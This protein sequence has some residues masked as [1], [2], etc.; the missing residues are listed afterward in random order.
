MSQDL[1]TAIAAARLRIIEAPKLLAQIRLGSLQPA[2]GGRPYRYHFV[3]ENMRLWGKSLGEISD[4]AH[5]I[6]AI[7]D[8]ALTEAAF[9]QQKAQLGPKEWAKKYGPWSKGCSWEEIEQGW[10]EHAGLLQ[11]GNLT[12]LPDGVCALLVS[13]QHRT[14]VCLRLLAIEFG[15]SC[16]LD[17]PGCLL[18]CS[19][20]AFEIYQ[21][22]CLLALA[23]I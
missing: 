8:P 5:P 15:H 6:T 23:S 1:S 2:P 22:P 21:L 16:T 9:L 3:L 19:F 17:I 7:F 18:Y 12:A 10:K 4:R 14:Q 11:N 13:G 20:F